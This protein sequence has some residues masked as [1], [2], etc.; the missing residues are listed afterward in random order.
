VTKYTLAA[1]PSV[2][3]ATWSGVLAGPPGSNATWNAITAFHEQWARRLAPAGCTGYFYGRPAGTGR[4]RT[5]VHLAGAS[6]ATQLETLMR[7]VTSAVA[8]RGV[9]LAGV[10]TFRAARRGTAGGGSGAA[11]NDGPNPS[12]TGS[13][14]FP[15]NGQNKIVTSWLYGS[16]ELL[17][18]AATLRAALQGAVDGDTML[19]QDFEGGA[20]T[21]RPPMLRGGSSAVNPAWRRAV[22]RAAAELQWA[23][24]NRAKLAQ[25]KRDALRFGESLRRI[26]PDSG[27]YVNEA[28]PVSFP[29]SCRAPCLASLPPCIPSRSAN[30]ACRT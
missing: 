2:G 15:G 5:E 24:S 7:S 8:G 20:G 23:G 11:A 6:S 19:Y 21:A 25:R 13:R 26:A 30:R 28:D 10:P 17:L 22:V 16:R 4:M 14:A 1:F 18:P 9:T 27:C 12:G 3:I 29:S